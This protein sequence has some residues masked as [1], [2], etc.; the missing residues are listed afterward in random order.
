MAV[1]VGTAFLPVHDPEAAAPWYAKVLG[2]VATDVNQWSAQLRSPGAGS[3]ALTLMGPL[4]GIKA[5]PGLPFATCNFVVDDL[6]DL[7]DRLDAE[8]L[9]PS[10][11]NGWPE[12]CLFFTVNDPDGNLLLVVDR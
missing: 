3:T 10:P 1:S 5:E 12:M 4:S 6:E 7:H 11:V 8:G 9:A 2:L